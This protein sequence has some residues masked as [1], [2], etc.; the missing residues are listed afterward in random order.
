[1]RYSGHM[2]R[3]PQDEEFTRFTNALRQILTIPKVEL[4]NRI[5]ADKRKKQAT[6]SASRAAA[7]PSKER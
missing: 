1:M 3:T 4:Q 5:E 2:K 7:A 6:A